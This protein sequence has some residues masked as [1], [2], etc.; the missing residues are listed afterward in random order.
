MATISKFEQ[1]RARTDRELIALIDRALDRGVDLARC[2]DGRWPG[3]EK[4]C[5]EARKLLPKVYDHG[6]RLRLERKLKEV[7]D[8]LDE[9]STSEKPRMRAAAG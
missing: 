8:R 3:A 5:A 4:A 9:L 2:A 6:E 7:R 1:L